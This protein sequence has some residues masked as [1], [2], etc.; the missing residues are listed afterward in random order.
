MRVLMLSRDPH[1]FTVGSASWV[2]HEAYRALVDDL[3]VISIGKWF[4]K[5]DI[6][7][8]WKT[9]LIVAQDPFESGFFGVI[10]SKI[11][12]SDLQVQ[13]HTDVLNPLLKQESWLNRLRVNIARWVLP[14]ANCVRVVSRRIEESILSAGLVSKNRIT[15]IPIFTD[16]RTGKSDMVL[17]EKF[18][19]FTHVVLLVS[20]LTR[21]KNIPLAFHAFKKVLEKYPNACLVVLGSGPMRNKL[22]KLAETLGIARGVVFEGWVNDPSPYFIRANAYLM[23]SDYEGYALTLVEAAKNN[24]PIVTTDVGLVG[25]LL[26]KEEAVIVSPGDGEGIAR[27]LLETLI[28]PHDAKARARRAFEKTQTLPTWEEYLKTYQQSW[29]ICGKN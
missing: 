6:R 22:E 27:G 1:M 16:Q 7:S 24:C 14:R 10:L 23:T 15:R 9:D 19:R 13:V 5:I 25:D 26:G 3:S 29:I 28:H 18:S 2:R 11:L 8:F 20:R 4:F 21:E 17:E 12:R